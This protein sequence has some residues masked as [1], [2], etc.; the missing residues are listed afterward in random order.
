MSIIGRSRRVIT[1][2]GRSG[3]PQVH[4]AEN[5]RRYIMVRKKG[6]GIKRLYSGSKY[7]ENGKA[8]KLDLGGKI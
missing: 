3:R 5:G 4:E 1:Y 8:R 2:H 6:G 7:W